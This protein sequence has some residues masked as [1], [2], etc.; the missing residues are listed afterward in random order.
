MTNTFETY[1][2]IDCWS[3]GICGTT[4]SIDT[5]PNKVY[6]GTNMDVPVNFICDK[7]NES[8]DEGV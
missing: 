7:C 4:F 8:T 5:T 1:G 2:N 6:S 3:F